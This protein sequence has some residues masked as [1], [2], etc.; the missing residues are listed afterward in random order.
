MGEAIDRDE[1][2]D[3]WVSVGVAS[4]DALMDVAFAARID[5]DAAWLLAEAR[6]TAGQIGALEAQMWTYENMTG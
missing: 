6:D 3:G 1:S 2:S 4:I 5:G